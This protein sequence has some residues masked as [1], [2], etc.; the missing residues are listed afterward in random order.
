[1]CIKHLETDERR[2]YEL[3]FEDYHGYLVYHRQEPPKKDLEMV[4]LILDKWP[5]QKGRFSYELEIYSA[6]H[7]WQ[8]D[9]DIIR[10]NKGRWFA[11]DH[12]KFLDKFCPDLLDKIERETSDGA[13]R[14]FLAGNAKTIYI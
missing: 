7:T 12:K 6:Q 4:S 2:R 14:Q 13:L 3:N 10:D 5:N 11:S 1:M 8:G 9:V